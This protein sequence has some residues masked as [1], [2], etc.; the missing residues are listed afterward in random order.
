M[1]GNIIAKELKDA[2][3]HPYSK[4]NIQEA[5]KEVSLKYSHELECSEFVMPT[6]EK[7]FEDFSENKIGPFEV[8]MTVLNRNK[9]EDYVIEKLNPQN[10]TFT[11][12]DKEINLLDV[13]EIN[14]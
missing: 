6:L 9:V 4:E 5:I 3:K 12:K 7:Y 1:L 2:I 13:Y 11:C 10:G 14:I 8:G